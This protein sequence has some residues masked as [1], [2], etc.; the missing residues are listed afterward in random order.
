MQ[1]NTTWYYIQLS[2]NLVTE[3]EHQFEFVF[4]TDTPY[5]TL[6]G[7]LSGVYCEEFGENWPRFNGPI[8]Y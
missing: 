8:L 1:S 4:P 5:L 7:E 6:K 2:S 3:A